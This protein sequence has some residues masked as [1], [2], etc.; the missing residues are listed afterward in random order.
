MT[1]VTLQDDRIVRV[2]SEK[3]ASEQ[4]KISFYRIPK[5]HE[6]FADSHYIQLPE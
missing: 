3:K 4:V 1:R 6:T 5:S 2:V